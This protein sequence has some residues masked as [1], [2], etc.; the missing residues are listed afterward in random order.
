TQPALNIKGETLPTEGKTAKSGALTKSA[1]AESVCIT[2]PALNIKGETLPTEGKTA[3]SGALT[4]S[5][6]AESV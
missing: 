4:K 6:N 2:Q 5:A 1:N 3:K